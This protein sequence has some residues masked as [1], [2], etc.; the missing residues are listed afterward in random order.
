[1]LSHG[2]DEENTVFLTLDNSEGNKHDG[3]QALRH[4]LRTADADAILILHQ[5]VRFVSDG[6]DLLCERLA[7]LGR[8]DPHWAVAGNAG[9]NRSICSGAIHMNVEGTLCRTETVFPSPVLS[10]DENFLVIKPEADLTVSRD[11]T[12]FHLYGAELC[13]VAR[14]LGY[15]SYVI[16]FTIR[17]DSKGSLDESFYLAKMRLE[18]KYATYRFIDG[19]S[20][21][22]ARLCW[23]ASRFRRFWA[24]VQ[25]GAL[26]ELY[27]HPQSRKARSLMMGTNRRTILQRVVNRIAD[28]MIFGMTVTA[29]LGWKCARL[30]RTI[31]W[32]IIRNLQWWYE[33]WK[34]RLLP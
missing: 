1:M 30:R 6:Y 34:S 17:H 24:L 26:L 20:T 16:D 31:L 5:D 4:F 27:N 14:R 25:S 12:G 13:D 3:F 32:K 22:C 33:N 9:K 21:T 29:R 18:E 23:S 10:L 19:F 11:L 2:F 15:R 7:E 28:W 8:V